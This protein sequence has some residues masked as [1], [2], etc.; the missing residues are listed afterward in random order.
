[1]KRVL[2]IGGGHSE[3]PIINELKKSGYFVGTVGNNIDGLG[4][5]IADLNVFMDFSNEILVNDYFIQNNFDFVIPGCNDFAML[6]ASYISEMNKIG[7][8][9]SYEKTK[10]IHYKNNF[11]ELCEQN[12]L[13]APKAVSFSDV[14]NALTYIK[15]NI[16]D[17]KSL[18]IKPVD[19]TGGKGISK[20]NI[21]DNYE[22]LIRL[23]LNKSRLKKIVIEDFID[24][25]NHGFSC[26]IQNNKII[27]YFWDD[28]F[29]YI[30]NY[31]VAGTSY[32]GTSSK[33]T[34]DLLK[35]QLEIFAST[36]DL[37]DG[38]LHVQYIEKNNIP[39][40]IEV[41]RRPPGDLYLNFV[42]ESNLE[43]YTQIIIDF[44]IHNTISHFKIKNDTKYFARHCIKGY[45]QGIIKRIRFK[46]EL[47]DY[48][49][50]TFTIWDNN[51]YLEDYLTQKLSIIL[52]KFE[53]H[54]VANEMNNNLY[55][56]IDVQ[57]HINK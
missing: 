15:N 28:E 53:N 22:E 12:N 20:I 21:K 5:K 1:M 50:K 55:K 25:T 57:Y 35:S 45:K 27:W 7:N 14:E 29:Y 16:S 10:K 44:F 33:K 51:K 4:H 37:V 39:Y 24:G 31:S 13:N 46:N 48:I 47:Q 36:L 38:L 34:I 42:E 18:I 43:N 26:F 56:Y 40:I 23:A 9:D 30:D 17:K 8:F 49:F 11:R 54:E 19:L 32:P 6:T 41:M 52:M 2:V 3:L